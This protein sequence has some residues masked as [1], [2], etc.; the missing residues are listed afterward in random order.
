MKPERWQQLNDLFQA[1]VE[2]E[3]ARRAEFLDQACAGDEPLRKQLKSLLASDAVTWDLMEQPALEAAAPLLID[4]EPRL[5]P[6]EHIGHYEILNLI[7]TGGMGEV[8]LARDQKLNRKI[9][10]KLLSAN[11][12]T[13]DKDQL[14]RFQQEAQA[15]SA[16]NHPNILTIYELGEVDGEQF[17]ATEFIDG[18]TLRQH[19]KRSQLDLAKTLDIAIQAASALAAAHEA[20]LVHR[21][22]KPENIMVR[23]DGIV[24]VLDF[25]LAKLIEQRM[26]LANSEAFTA[27]KVEITTPGLV[28]GTV[29]YMSPEQARGLTVDARSDIFSLGVVLYEL[30]TR[31]APFEGETVSD[32]IAAILKEEPRP[33][34]E[35]SSNVPGE[36]QHI[37]TTALCK[38]K[39][40]RYQTIQQL[41]SDLKE[42]NRKLEFQSPP[43]E[44]TPG[45]PI[46][47]GGVATGNERGL[48]TKS[49]E[50]TRTVSSAE[51][52][53]DEIKRHKTGATIAVILALA[54]T[55]AI[56]FMSYRFARKHWPAAAAQETKLTRI[57]TSGTA[58][59][60]AI[61]PDG[62]YLVYVNSVEGMNSIWLRQI[63]TSSNVQILSLEN[64]FCWG[65][66]FSRD[67]DY[68][69]YF[70]QDKTEQTASLYKMPALGG[71]ISSKLMEGIST[72]ASP[73]T[74]SPDGGRLAFV[75]EYDSGESAVVAVNVDGS[76]ERKIASAVAEGSRFLS[77]AWSPD[78]E[79]IA[80]ASVRRLASG[81]MKAGVIE[82]DSESG[83]QKPITDERWAWIENI[84]WLSDSSGLLITSSYTQGDP[85]NVSLI[86]YP[87]GSARR[88]VTDLNGYGGLSLS[89]DSNALVSTRSDSG[90]NIWTQP[91]DNVN[92]ARQTTS[93]VATNDGRSGLSWTPDGRIVYSSRASG[94][95]DIWITDADGKNQKQLTVDLGSNF[96]GLS[97][98]PDGRYTVFV[99]QSAGPAHIW[100]MDADGGNPRQL[101]FGKWEINPVFLPGGQWISYAE[102]V[103]GKGVQRKTPVESG[104][105]DVLDR[106]DANGGIPRDIVGISP[107]GQLVA[108]IPPRDQKTPNKG[109]QIAIAR[110]DGGDPIRVFDLPAEAAPRRMQ[111]S[112]D[113]SAL[114]YIIDSGQAANIWSQPIDGSPP[115]QL[116]DFK[117]SSVHCFA[118]SRDGK[119]LAMARGTGT[120]DIVLISNFR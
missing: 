64:R 49:L 47:G 83:A 48:S 50:W 66:T 74:F 18:E 94:H 103:S 5:N 79:R 87:G 115:R 65:L 107:D 6:G 35:Y 82:I 92:R 53:I 93:G 114:T 33:L 54:A 30:L 72:T 60:A 3:P 27:R 109:K 13:K 99:S 112:P 84:V 10:L 90:M 4:D 88:V 102:L 11:R 104:T 39:R 26:A 118:W 62:R 25:G 56:A 22:V 42:L 63:A 98:S 68:I 28:L 105:A 34:S 89:T 15:A 75:R 70:G 16:L 80:C 46:R 20:G 8:Y 96:F 85:L 21:D 31:H 45:A 55:A 52:V 113:G 61:S 91:A 86:T 71:G 23:R 19:L 101:T 9:A 59:N 51:Y 77:A 67:G 100:R 73:I 69:F 1:A 24:K 14:R 40:E 106:A 58:S 12:Y 29:K 81:E 111:W 41:V 120:N 2:M 108:F 44:T 78:G 36:L 97:V 43:F 119:Q 116:T 110:Y 57:T 32:Q 95:P 37:L 38:D 117:S 7:G 76:G 17:I